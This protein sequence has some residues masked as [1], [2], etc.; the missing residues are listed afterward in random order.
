MDHRPVTAAVVRSGGLAVELAGPAPLPP[1]VA[2]FAAGLSRLLP[3]PAGGPGTPL[4]LEV[5]RDAGA[6]AAARS[7]FERGTLPVGGLL[8]ALPQNGHV[9]VR[10]ADDGDTVLLRWTDAGLLEARRHSGR[11]VLHAETPAPHLTWMLCYLTATTFARAGLCHAVHGS[12]VRL[13]GRN[14]MV[15]GGSSSGKTTLSLL[16][17]EGGAELVT[18]DVTYV[19]PAGRFLPVLLRDYLTVRAGTYAAMR[20]FFADRLGG[21]LDGAFPTDLPPEELYALGRA[22]QRMVPIAALTGDPAGRDRPEPVDLTLLPDVS[23]RHTGVRL[24]PATVAGANALIAGSLPRL[25]LDW[26][27]ELL[28]PDAPGPAAAGGPLPPGHP[29]LHVR[30]GLD[31]RAHRA[32]LLTALTAPTPA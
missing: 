23:P 20:D 3:A 1:R 31:H 24:E 6:L 26:V 22:G 8:G 4:R 27:G 25:M 5:V 19:D 12:V 13:A 10:L 17:V 30:L 32:E 18:E 29:V 7:R 28:P 14:V 9:Q 2:L 11:A 15:V 16:L 21:S